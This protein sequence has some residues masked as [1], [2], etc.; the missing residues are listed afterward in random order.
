MIRLDF[1]LRPKNLSNPWHLPR[2]T[3]LARAYAGVFWSARKYYGPNWAMPD[4]ELSPGA[5]TLLE[6]FRRNG[7]IRIENRF[8]DIAEYLDNAYFHELEN[9]GSNPFVIES[10][11]ARYTK[12][13]WHEIN[14][15]ISFKDSRL[16]PLFFDRELN[17]VLRNYY[18]RQPYFR[19]QP[20]LQRID[21]TDQT[22]S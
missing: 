5:S 17:G 18:G 10:T 21:T 4:V 1:T 19:N 13:L 7:I 16:A 14:A 9:D 6:E 8:A 15:R 12:T 11:V 20:L 3:V 2:P 22:A